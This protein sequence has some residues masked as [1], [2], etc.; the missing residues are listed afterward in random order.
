MSQLLILGNPNRH[1]FCNA[2][3]AAQSKSKERLKDIYVIHSKES[4]DEL[5]IKETDWMEF[6]KEYGI[7]ESTFINRIIGNEEELL[8]YLE[9]ILNICNIE[10]LI[11]DMSNGTSRMK[12]ILS[13]ITY[14]LDIS[15]VYAFDRVSWLNDGKKDK[16]FYHEEEL[17]NY[18]KKVVNNKDI[19]NLSWINLTQIVR[20]KEK[21][22]QFSSA[23]SDFSKEFANSSFFEENLY[24][25]ISLIMKSSNK[26][27][28]N[29][30]YRISSTAIATSLEDLVDRFL[31]DHGE[32]IKNLTLGQKLRCLKDKIK[33]LTSINLDYEFM[34]RFNEFM[35]YLRNSTTHKTLDILD[36]ERFK[37]ELSL[38]MSF[39]FFEYYTI[40]FQELKKSNYDNCSKV[41]E[42]EPKILDDKK[43]RYYGVDGDN[44]GLFLEDL[45][46]G[47]SDDEELKKFSNRIT[48]AKGKIVKYI[49]SL[50]KDAIIFAEGDDILFKGNF[51]IDHLKKIQEIYNQATNDKETGSLTCSIG[52]GKTP[53]EALFAMKL[54][55]IEKNSIKGIEIASNT[56][57]RVTN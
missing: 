57:L 54:A 27:K 44:T 50:K 36:S 23:Y 56:D 17:K 53:R 14:V 38:Q 20:Y 21:I 4:F 33:K 22:R 28:K 51:G 7:M 8:N 24:D 18:Y 35:L 1:N 19:D 39:V 26:E 43:E 46:R 13:I 11:I 41:L 49:K 29:T 40:I 31:L 42:L 9:C 12:T 47:N 48:E 34:G 32:D 55:K 45:L 5:F 15:N 3:V 37:A 52:Y 30:L 6:L 10:E 25:A 16:E 2:I